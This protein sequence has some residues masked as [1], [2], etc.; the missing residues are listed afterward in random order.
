MTVENTAWIFIF[1]PTVGH[2]SVDKHIQATQRWLRRTVGHYLPHR[3]LFQHER[4]SH[5]SLSFYLA[6]LKWAG[7]M[8]CQTFLCTDGNL[9][10]I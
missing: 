6:G 8:S 5:F 9:Y 1:R 10:N 7:K 4:F 3:T 2:G